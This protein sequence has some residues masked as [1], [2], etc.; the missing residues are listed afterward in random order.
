MCVCTT[1]VSYGMEDEIP[2]Y[3]LDSDDEEWLNQH[4]EHLP[5][6]FQISADKFELIFGKIE[7]ML[8]HGPVSASELTSIAGKEERMYKVIYEYM[9]KRLKK[10]G[11]ATVTPMV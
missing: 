5:E 6:K 3:D 1:P 2:T 11:T 9:K 8:A 10:L 7:S 4:N